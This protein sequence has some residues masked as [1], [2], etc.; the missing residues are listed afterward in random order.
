MPLRQRSVEFWYHSESD[1]SS[2]KTHTS[3]RQSR[4][5]KGVPSGNSCRWNEKKMTQIDSISRTEG[6]EQGE[7]WSAP[8]ILLQP[9]PLSNIIIR[10]RVC[11][12]VREFQRITPWILINFVPSGGFETGRCQKKIN[13]P[14][15]RAGVSFQFNAILSLVLTSVRNKGVKYICLL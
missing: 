13:T 14:R 3:H 4:S 2:N 12:T 7:K 5:Y 9:Y 11:H 10:T 15:M 8:F 1:V 6:E